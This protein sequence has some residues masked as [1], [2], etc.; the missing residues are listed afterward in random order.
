MK[1]F[2]DLESQI[3]LEGL[4]ELHFK[5]CLGIAKSR[6][7]STTRLIPHYEMT[8]QFQKAVDYKNF[9]PT[10]VGGINEIEP[11]VPG[12]TDEEIKE[13]NEL[14]IYEKKDFLELFAKGYCDGYI[15]PITYT[16]KNP[17]TEFSAFYKDQCPPSINMQYFPELMDWITHKTPFIH[18]GRILILKTTNHLHGDMHYDRRDEW[19]DGRHHFIWFN[20][21]NMKKFFLVDGYE[22]IYVNTKAAFFNM[23]LLH[24]AEPSPFATYSLRIDGQLSEEFCKAN[25]ILWKK[26]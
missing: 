21:F 8:G 13:Y 16:P 18:V 2:Y 3:D 26:R 12:L 19:N 9:E 20:P 1:P 22:K 23:N 17:K 7:F 14:S 24:G 25:D 11:P 15:V 4:E 5:I 10:R 6:K